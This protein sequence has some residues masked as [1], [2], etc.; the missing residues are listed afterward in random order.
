MSE[1][2]YNDLAATAK[3]L[4]DEFGVDWTLKSSSR[5]TYDPVLNTKPT[6]SI[7]ST[8]VKVV[9]FEYSE[10]EVNNETIKMGDCKVILSA[11]TSN[12]DRQDT[13]VDPDGVTWSIVKV[14]DTKPGGSVIYHELQIRK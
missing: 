14:M 11:Q 9:R 7:T 1:A 12:I 2:F 10:K 5:G 6:E 13:I 8:T 4:I 3:D